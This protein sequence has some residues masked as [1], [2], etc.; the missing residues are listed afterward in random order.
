MGLELGSAITIRQRQ[1]T[2]PKAR[3]EHQVSRLVA[4]INFIQDFGHCSFPRYGL[5]KPQPYGTP[6][7]WP[8]GDGRLSGL[9]PNMGTSMK[10]RTQF[11]HRLDTWDDASQIIEHLAAIEEFEV[12]GATY[13]AAVKA[14]AESLHDPRPLS[15][16]AIRKNIEPPSCFR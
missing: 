14:M 13:R 8:N 2:G 11:T 1:G 3:L 6:A 15:Q 7:P 10:T 12:A 5:P 9:G 16:S 4:A